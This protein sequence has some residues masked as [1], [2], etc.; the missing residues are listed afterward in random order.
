MSLLLALCVQFYEVMATKMA[1]LKNSRD[2][3][4][5]FLGNQNISLK[6]TEPN[7]HEISGRN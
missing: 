5:D 1:C 6:V 7:K 3:G 2:R 4:S